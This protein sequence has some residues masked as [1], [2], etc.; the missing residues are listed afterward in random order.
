MEIYLK[1]GYSRVVKNNEFIEIEELL[2]AGNLPD[3]PDGFE[4]LIDRLSLQPEGDELSRLA[5]SAESA[6]FEGQ[7]RM[8]VLVWDE[9]R[10]VRRHDFSKRFEADGITLPGAGRSHV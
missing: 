4:L 5:D 9:N 6:F 10:D 7:G 1:G 2:S 3:L 8:S